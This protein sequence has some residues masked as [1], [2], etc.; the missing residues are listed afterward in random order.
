MPASTQAPPQYT[1]FARVPLA[2][3]LPLSGERAQFA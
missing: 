2:Y 1:R 3:A